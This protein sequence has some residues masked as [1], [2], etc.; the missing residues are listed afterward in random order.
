MDRILHQ[1]SLSTLNR[2]D[3]GVGHLEGT[4]TL[5]RSRWCRILSTDRRKACFFFWAR[6]RFGLGASLNCT[7]SPPQRPSHGVLSTTLSGAVSQFRALSHEASLEESQR[8][9]L[10]SMGCQLIYICM[11]VFGS[12]PER[13]DSV[14]WCGFNSKNRSSPPLHGVSSGGRPRIWVQDTARMANALVKGSC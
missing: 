9:S 5:D 13:S 6:V 3:Q 1:K 7:S 14:G 12:C 8:C 11:R 2:G 10:S 4:A